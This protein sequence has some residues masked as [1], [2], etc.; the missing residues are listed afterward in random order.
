M[1]DTVPEPSIET[2]RLFV[3]TVRLGSLSRAA[4]EAGLAQPS[5][6]AR[7]RHLERQLGM[8]LLERRPTGSVPTDAGILV[9]EWAAAVIDV[10][11]HFRAA[12]GALRRERTGRLRIVASYTVAEYLLPAWLAR[13]HRRQDSVTVELEVANSAHV[14]QRVREGL[15]DLG[16]V[17]APEVPPDLASRDIAT[18]ELVVVAHPS[19][20]WSRR[21]SALPAA[22]LAAASLVVR[23]VGSGTRD[24]L[25]RAVAAA[26][27]GPLRAE[28]ELGSTSAVK[29]AVLDAAGP[30]VLSALAVRAEVATGQLVVVPVAGLDLHRVLRSVWSGQHPLAP[31][32]AA[33]LEGL[34]PVAQPAAPGPV[35][36]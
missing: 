8:A 9:A 1:P 33:F 24:S 20:S 17:E 19:H 28:L 16:F 26:G 23:E 4:A 21:R 22:S 34:P 14:V 13:F 35:S 3:A 18:D 12:V 36:G 7:L 27:I 6:S 10:A 5:A 30:A 2:L 32:A 11:D 29:A 25:E 31:V 15:A